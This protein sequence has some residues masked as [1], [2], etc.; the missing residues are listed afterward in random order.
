MGGGLKAPTPQVFSFGKRP[1]SSRVKSTHK[2]L[3]IIDRHT[4][5]PLVC[6]LLEDLGS[7]GHGLETTAAV[8]FA[9]EVVD[10]LTKR[11]HTTVL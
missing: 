4:V 9:W 8:F 1:K 3:S 5:T 2:D 7:L 10:K 6:A 11:K